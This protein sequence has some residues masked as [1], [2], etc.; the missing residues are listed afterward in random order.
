MTHRILLVDDEE[1]LRKMMRLTLEATGYE[2]GEATDGLEAFDRFGDGSGWDAVL[3]DQRMPGIDGLETLRRITSRRAETPIVMVTAYASI[4]RRLR[5]SYA[6]RT[7]SA[8]PLRPTSRAA[9][10]Q[11]EGEGRPPR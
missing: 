11:D 1:H 8:T 5:S 4:A 3:L 6:T 10:T 9:S 2:I 7:G